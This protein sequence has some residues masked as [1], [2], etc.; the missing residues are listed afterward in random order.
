MRT[1]PPTHQSS[2]S[3]PTQPIPYHPILNTQVG[4]LEASVGPFLLSAEY[5]Q[6][7]EEVAALCTKLAA[8]LSGAFGGAG[9]SIG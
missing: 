4:D 9:A 6:A 5:A 1:M 7:D 8:A 3:A 2:I